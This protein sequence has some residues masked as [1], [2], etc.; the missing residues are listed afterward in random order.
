METQPFVGKGSVDCSVKGKRVG[1]HI[2][3]LLGLWSAQGL[4]V[5]CC[6]GSGG[7]A[8]YLSI[9]F[10]QYCFS[11]LGRLEC[12]TSVRTLDESFS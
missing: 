9:P 10:L 1:R 7:A 11:R 6:A 5:Y 3:C 8:K 4:G 12:A 2:G